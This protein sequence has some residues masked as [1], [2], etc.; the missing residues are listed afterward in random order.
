MSA[1]DS[2]PPYDSTHPFNIGHHN[3]E[4]ALS[5][6][7][8]N[9]FF[10]DSSPSSD[11]DCLFPN[12]PRDS[13]D[14]VLAR[15][16]QFYLDNSSPVN[17]SR[18]SPVIGS[19][20]AFSGSFEATRSLV[21]AL[22]R[23][24]GPR[25]F[26]H[27]Y[28]DILAPQP[29]RLLALLLPNFEV[30]QCVPLPSSPQISL[31]SRQAELRAYYQISAEGA[32]VRD[33]TDTIQGNSI[34]V[35]FWE[36]ADYNAEDT[37]IIEIQAAFLPHKCFTT[38]SRINDHMFRGE[39]SLETPTAHA[40]EFFLSDLNNSRTSYKFSSQPDPLLA[41]ASPYTF[42]GTPPPPLADIAIH[43]PS[44]S[45]PQ[46][47]QYQWATSSDSGRSQ[48]TLGQP[49][50]SPFEHI[51]E[52][53][54]GSGEDYP[55]PRTRISLA[56]IQPLPQDSDSDALILLFKFRSTSPT[57]APKTDASTSIKIHGENGYQSGSLKAWFEEGTIELHAN[58]PNLSSLF[59]KIWDMPESAFLLGSPIGDAY[60]LP[61]IHSH[62]RLSMDNVKCLAYLVGNT[63]PPIHNSSSSLTD[64]EDLKLPSKM[65]LVG[66]WQNLAHP[67]L[68]V[69]FR[70]VFVTRPRKKLK[71]ALPRPA[72]RHEEDANDQLPW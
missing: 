64:L 34:D 56:P 11:I 4:S 60:S 36:S 21:N 3:N 44:P 72:T 66:C 19:E 50:T 22:S 54:H 65:C 9:I 46:P 67:D 58:E 41:T 2:I 7:P 30:A 28:P 55:R 13:D 37:A 25:D 71:N 16:D 49:E 39:S 35:S 53:A 29:R 8:G 26:E 18:D 61:R 45:T 27:R 15:F 47:R 23:M 63:L 17:S 31:T 62:L 51:R 12:P 40:E 20:N 1:H 52:P 24:R 6:P 33:E 59:T 70:Q 5:N 68:G 57:P 10:T 38:R 42:L 69:P 43:D 14:E 48:F 32:N